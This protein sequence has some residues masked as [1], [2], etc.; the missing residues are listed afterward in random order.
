MEDEQRAARLARLRG[1]SGGGS[2][3]HRVGTSVAP[4]ESRRRPSL[5]PYRS[6]STT[7][8][9][10]VSLSGRDTASTIDA[11]ERRM[12]DTA[13]LVN[14]LKVPTRTEIIAEPPIR[15]AEAE[16]DAG[17]KASAGNLAAMLAHRFSPEAVP[18]Q[19][20]PQPLQKPAL[21]LAQQPVQDTAQ[22]ELQLTPATAAPVP[23]ASTFRPSHVGDSSRES[24]QEFLAP[25]PSPLVTTSS[26]V[27]ELAKLHKLRRE[28]SITDEEITKARQQLLRSRS[29]VAAS[30]RSQPRGVSAGTPLT[31]SSQPAG[32]LFSGALGTNFGK[33]SA[34]ATLLSKLQRDA[35]QNNNPTQQLLQKLDND[36][37]GAYTARATTYTALP[38]PTVSSSG[39]VVNLSLA[40]MDT[41]R[42]TANT[43][44]GKAH[45]KQVTSSAPGVA[46]SPGI[47]FGFGQ[48]SPR[49]E[50]DDATKLL[51]RL[52][53]DIMAIGATRSS[54]RVRCLSATTPFCAALDHRTDV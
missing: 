6:P 25:P 45:L 46:R 54:H 17:E 33:V 18:A 24:V 7:T 30:P 31:A 50:D 26:V 13:S 12:S 43:W 9:S 52:E 1:S 20:A 16:S 47:G 2:R 37:R 11:S 21:R 40:S 22:R 53:G 14:T 29:T 32:V 8:I 36:M 23:V 28:G 5:E 49:G 10:E 35:E 19:P 42:P 41:P 3:S 4:L 48:P 44:H 34:S 15:L 27:T 39:S 51:R 38:T